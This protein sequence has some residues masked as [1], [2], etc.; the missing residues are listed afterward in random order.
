VFLGKF[1]DVKYVQQMQ[2]EFSADNDRPI[3]D[4]V[5]KKIEACKTVEEMNTIRKEVMPDFK[6]VTN[7][8]EKQRM[9]T[10][11]Q[12]KRDEFPDNQL[13]EGE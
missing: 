11:M 5:I 6:S 9:S 8:A 1:D 7:K 10:A 12:K 4:K 13:N 3:A 2:Q